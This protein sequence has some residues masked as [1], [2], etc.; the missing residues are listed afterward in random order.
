[1]I[2]F[3]DDEVE[4]LAAIFECK[5][6]DMLRRGKFTN[7]EA[8]RATRMRGWFGTSSLTIAKIWILLEENVGDDWPEPATKERLLWAFLFMKSYDTEI[9]A[10]AR[11]GGVDEQTFRVW[12]WWFVE[13]MA[14]LETTVVR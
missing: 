2:P 6:F 3:D 8:V 5:A 4:A 11:C 14:N 1:M 7:S 10:A 9:N 12:A 13:E